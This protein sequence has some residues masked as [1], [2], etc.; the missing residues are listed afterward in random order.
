M[1]YYHLRDAARRAHHVRSTH[2]HTHTI[3]RNFSIYALFCVQ[4][5]HTASHTHTTLKRFIVFDNCTFNVLYAHLHSH[6]CCAVAPWRR[7]RK[8]C[9]HSHANNGEHLQVRK[10]VHI[11]FRQCKIMRNALQLIPT[12]RLMIAAAA[13][14]STEREWVRWAAVCVR[15][16]SS[17]KEWREPTTFS[18]HFIQ[19][20]EQR[21]IVQL[22]F[23]WCVIMNIHCAPSRSLS[24]S[25][26]VPL[27]LTHALQWLASGWC[28]DWHRFKCF[29]HSSGNWL[30]DRTATWQHARN[31]MTKC[32]RTGI[33]E[34]CKRPALGECTIAHGAWWIYTQ[35][36]RFAQCCA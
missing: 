21:E 6:G 32:V 30:P 19:H 18:V 8:I 9:S 25:L 33:N 14:Q 3:H 29:M 24:I 34:R 10:W 4:V 7:R 36:N 26:F 35:I 1:D 13:L 23:E 28:R 22:W 17:W 11:N 16:T 5:P 12:R 31:N 15:K 20:N 27:A 2:R